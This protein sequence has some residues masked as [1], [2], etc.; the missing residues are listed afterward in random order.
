MVGANQT[1]CSESPGVDQDLANGLA[2][3]A[4]ALED[5]VLG[6]ERAERTRNVGQGEN[7]SFVDLR[8]LADNVFYQKIDE[9]NAR[10]LP[11]YYFRYVDTYLK[12][13]TL[14][15]DSVRRRLAYVLRK[16]EDA[17]ASSSDSMDDELNH[18]YDNIKDSSFNGQGFGVFRNRLCEHLGRDN[19][20][21]SGRASFVGRKPLIDFKL[22]ALQKEKIK[23]ESLRK[24]EKSLRV[25]A[26]S[27]PTTSSNSKKDVD[28]MGQ[29]IA[30]S[31]NSTP[32]NNSARIWDSGVGDCA[33]DDE[34]SDEKGVKRSNGAA[35]DE[36]T[37]IPRP[38]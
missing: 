12:N 24:S 36:V 35:A 25:S 19:S 3:R 14:W 11:K 28:L 20:N 27:I 30:R 15:I 32:N 26:V 8:R 2:A 38:G 7:E 23:K 10:S 5:S 9:L 22:L 29:L 16:L 1:F 13:E 4:L 6:E 21:N 18:L 33:S 37:S 34:W 31:N 17:M